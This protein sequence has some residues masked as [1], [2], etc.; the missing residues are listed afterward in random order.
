M[1]LHPKGAV[2]V[3]PSLPVEGSPQQRCTQFIASSLQA[4]MQ[5]LSPILQLFTQPRLATLHAVMQSIAGGA[6]GLEGGSGKPGGDGGSG[7]GGRAVDPRG[8]ARAGSCGFSSTH[9]PAHAL[10][11]PMTTST[12]S[13]LGDRV[14]VP[15]QP[16]FVSKLQLLS[17][18]H[19]IDANSAEPE[20]PI[21]I[22]PR[23]TGL[24]PSSMDWD[25]PADGP[26]TLIPVGVR[27]RWAVA[28]VTPSGEDSWRS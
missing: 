19:R 1:D 7:A 20:D 23:R 9:L 13:P 4:C 27:Y 15:S 8:A 22:L 21:W 2:G 28:T 24:S 5:A 6:G 25:I 11:S 17:S 26:V 3:E 18:S 10:Q 12:M 14:I 16:F